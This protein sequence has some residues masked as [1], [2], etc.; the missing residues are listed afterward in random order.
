M[1]LNG[2]R[3]FC[4][5]LMN[6]Y[7]NCIINE[8]TN[9]ETHSRNGYAGI[10]HHGRDATHGECDARRTGCLYPEEVGIDSG[11][12]RE[13]EICLSGRGV[14]HLSHLL[15]YYRGGGRTLCLEE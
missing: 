9:L 7:E 15:S 12:N 10:L 6:S 4:P 2:H 8:R 14:A 11:R 13:P 5:I 3:L 1:C